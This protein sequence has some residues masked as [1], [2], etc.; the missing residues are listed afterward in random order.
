MNK[1]GQQKW[2]LILQK[3]MNDYIIYNYSILYMYVSNTADFKK[4]ATESG[5]AEPWTEFIIVFLFFH[6]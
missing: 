4:K 6:P 2:V 5:V 3:T 1:N